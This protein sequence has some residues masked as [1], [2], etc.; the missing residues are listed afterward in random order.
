MTKLIFI[1]MATICEYATDD[2]YE[3]NEFIKIHG[4]YTIASSDD[5]D[6]QN[7]INRAIA[8]GIHQSLETAHL[9]ITE[10]AINGGKTI[11]HRLKNIPDIET[12]MKYVEQSISFSC[13]S[14]NQETPYITATYKPNNCTIEVEFPYSEYIVQLTVHEI[15]EQNV[16]YFAMENFLS[17]T[18]G[19]SNVVRFYQR[20]FF[21]Q[22][23]A[24][25]ALE[26]M[27]THAEISGRTSRKEL[28]ILDAGKMKTNS[29]YLTNL[30]VID[31]IEQHPEKNT[32]DRFNI[33]AQGHYDNLIK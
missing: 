25:E 30:K 27:Q 10:S 23:E 32:D 18:E 33:W 19:I 1:E 12:I 11:T 29:W 9:D 16:L 21:T 22:K 5:P 14:D 28:I 20:P 2:C 7:K 4:S 26:H 15:E 6:K 17:P 3:L 8:V 31:Y 24:E 13:V